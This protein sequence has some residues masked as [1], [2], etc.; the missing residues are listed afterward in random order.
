MQCHHARGFVQRQIAAMKYNGAKESLLHRQMKLWLVESLYA[1]GQFTD[2][3][4]EKRW[5]GTI[6]S[7]WRKPDVRAVFGGT[8]IAFE[9]QLSTTFLDV[10]VERRRFYLR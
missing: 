8:P 7:E 2:I 3:R 5:Q 1:S 4:Q 9:I 10:I 6:T